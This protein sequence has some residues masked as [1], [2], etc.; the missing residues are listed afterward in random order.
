MN[1]YKILRTTSEN[2]D[3]VRL[4]AELDAYLAI[5]NGENNDFFVQFNQIEKLHHVVLVFEN[6]LAVGCGAFKEIETGTVEI[7]RMFVPTAFRGKGMAS[8]VVNE[9]ENWAKELGFKN[10]VL[11]TG[12]DMKDAVGLYTNS[13]YKI[14]PNYGP[15]KDVESSICFAKTL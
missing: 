1:S 7:K 4:V 11:E 10:S 5:R 15:Y 8:M 3:F 6:E 9:L 13:N 12:K 2:H 14:I